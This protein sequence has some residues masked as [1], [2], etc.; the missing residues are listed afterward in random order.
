MSF[1]LRSN[2]GMAIN[3]DSTSDA[4]AREEPVME[5]SKIYSS[6]EYNCSKYDEDAGGVLK[7]QLVVGR[8]NHWNYTVEITYHLYRVFSLAY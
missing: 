8:E 3:L 7:R 5:H 1:E 2:R 4:I 6:R